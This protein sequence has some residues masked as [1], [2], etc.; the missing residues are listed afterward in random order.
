MLTPELNKLLDLP[1][2]LASYDE[3]V[4]KVDQKFPPFDLY[5]LQIL[6]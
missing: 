3:T 5:S 1:I 6:N 2:I 4:E